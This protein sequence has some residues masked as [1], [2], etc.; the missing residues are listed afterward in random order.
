MFDFL[1]LRLDDLQKLLVF[2]L[3]SLDRYNFMCTPGFV[4]FINVGMFHVF[5]NLKQMTFTFSK[6]II[7]N[8]LS[9]LVV[10]HLILF[11]YQ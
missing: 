9:L 8:G 5:A 3:D 7:Q 1:F 10:V 6:L 4:N 11:Y 2:L